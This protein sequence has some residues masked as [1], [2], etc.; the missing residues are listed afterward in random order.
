MGDHI[1]DE[2]IDATGVRR[3]EDVMNVSWQ[4]LHGDESSPHRIVEI[5]IDIGNAVGD[6]DD[7]SFEGVRLS[8]RR[9]GNAGTKL[10]VTENTVAD[11]KREVEAVTIPLQVIDDAQALLV[12]AKAREGL[13][14][15]H[16]PG[17]PKRGMPEVVSEADRLDQ[18]LVES[19]RAADR[20]SD[21][22]H[23]ERVHQSCAV[24][25]PG[26]S[27]K[28]LGL[29]HQPAEALGVE[30]PIAIALE[31]GPQIALRVGCGSQRATTS[32]AGG[33]KEEFFPLL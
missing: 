30:D 9:V 22:R 20:A 3:T 16:L 1:G 26:G 12:M 21:L 2:R 33:S 4:G 29:V 6:A 15:G 10:G 5:V 28:D 18:I 17:M 13:G 27:D 23:F 11:R 24:V 19:Q 31:C 8:R 7:F 25:V 32:G 14:Q